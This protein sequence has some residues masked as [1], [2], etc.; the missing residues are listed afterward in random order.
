MVQAASGVNETHAANRSN[1]RSIW[2]NGHG[3]GRQHRLGAVTGEAGQQPVHFEGRPRPYAF[4]RRVAGLSEE[5]RR[6]QVHAVALLVEGQLGELGALFVAQRH[7]ILRTAFIRLGLDND[8]NY[9]EYEIPLT[10]TPRGTSP[11]GTPND[12]EEY[13]A[14]VWLEENSFDMDLKQFIALKVARDQAG[15]A[16]QLPYELIDEEKP[17]NAYRIVGNPDLGLVEGMMI[18]VRNTKDDGAT[19]CAE[20]WVNELRVNGFDERGGYAGRARMDMTLADFGQV[21]VSGNYTSIGW[22]SLE[23]RV[24]ERAREEVL[25]YDVAGSFQLDKFLP[26]KYG[27]RL[28]IYAQYSQTLRTPEYDPYKFDIPLKE[29]VAA[30]ADPMVR[31]SLREQAQTITTIK[32]VN[33]TNIRKER[34]N[35][36]KKPRPWNVEN[37]SV[38]GAY[39]ETTRSDPTIQTDAV[40]QYRGGLDYGYSTQPNYVTPFQNIIKSQSKYVKIIKDFNFNPFPNSINFN[41]GINRRF[42]ET[43]YRF[44]GDAENATWFD[45]RFMWDRVYGV[46]WNMARSL[47]INFNATNN[48]VIDEPV[49]RLDTPEKQDSVLNNIRNFG[50]N[51]NYTHTFTASYTLPFKKIPPLDWINVKATYNANYGWSAAALNVD[52]LGNTILNGNARQLNAD[53]DFEQLYNKSEYLKKIN[54]NAK[55]APKMDDELREEKKNLDLNQ[56]IKKKKKRRKRKKNQLRLQEQSSDR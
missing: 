32:S 8:Y 24:A 36:D 43:T 48:A 41:T 46:N 16:L 5:L 20:V 10:M 14:Q 18:G 7:D 37:V 52:S 25:Q 29:L 54:S 53:L 28:P 26:K 22:G 49:G 2:P 51:K 30:Q 35:T 4:E 13:K 55:N 34:T 56:A 19:H 33:M 31:D 12:D 47:N 17:N 11:R 44:A 3:H 23:Q 40:R 42:A 45:K 21:T 1:H 38:T 15:A 27:I 39:S 9:Y 6:A 50:R